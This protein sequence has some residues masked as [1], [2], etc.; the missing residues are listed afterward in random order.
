MD[1]LTFT[2]SDM[3]AGYVTRRDAAGDSFGLKTTDGRE[4]TVFLTSTTVA[5]LMRNLGE[6]YHDAT[7]QMREM[8]APGRYLFA[9]GVFYPQGGSHKFEAKH[10]V[11]C[12]A[13]ENEFRFE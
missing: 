10:L 6:P 13:T 2:V 12:G 5:E 9:Y 4:F 1:K 8:L 3:I 11:F 7:G